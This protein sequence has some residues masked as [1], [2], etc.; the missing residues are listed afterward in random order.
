MKTLFLITALFLAPAS[1]AAR[2]EGDEKQVWQSHWEVAKS[3]RAQEQFEQAGRAFELAIVQIEKSRRDL[4]LGIFKTDFFQDKVKVYQQYVDL[5]AMQLV[6]P[7]RAFQISERARARSFL[8]SLAEVRADLHGTLPEKLV[9]KEEMIL[10]RISLLQAEIRRGETNPD[11][12]EDLSQNEEELQRLYLDLRTQYPAFHAFRYPEAADLRSVQDR[13]G[14]SEL[15]VQYFVGEEQSHLWLVSRVGVEHHLLPGRE[16]LEASV[17]KAYRSLLDPDQPPIG[18]EELSNLLLPAGDQWR[19]N[20]EAVTIVPSGL[21]YYFPFEVLR[22]GER[23]LGD[24]AQ[25][26]YLPSASALTYLRD[27][28]ERA[29]SSPRLLAVGDADYSGHQEVE[30]SASMRGLKA[31]GALPFTRAEV[32]KIRAVFGYF[33]STLLVGERATEARLKKLELSD[34]SVLHLAAHGWIDPLLPSRSGIVLGLDEDG[35]EDGI[36]Q[37][38]E[39]FRLPLNAQLVTLS[40]CQTA[41]GKL[42]TGE[43]MV[44]L[45]QAFFFAGASSVVASLWNVNDEATA[46]FMSLFYGHLGDG[47]SKVEAL[48]RARSDLRRDERYRHPYYW[49]PYILIGEAQKGVTFPASEMRVRLILG[50]V[51]L[52][53]ISIYFMKR[54]FAA[55]SWDGEA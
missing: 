47:L 49:A 35:Q 5:L 4:R 13:L 12:K 9:E 28:P 39:V 52:V 7:D 34:F 38:G 54:G 2:Q 24:L 16:E 1:I 55:S 43:G 20:H 19:E 3:F 44:G 45:T 8:D 37:A 27:I 51:L 40:A 21:L 26:A 33:D 29:I 31:L 50:L 6:A 18:L 48:R 41:L 22:R 36:L 17:K 53:C 30:G 46:R 42:V 15:L 14:D 10:D 11:L 23:T 25:T 32:S